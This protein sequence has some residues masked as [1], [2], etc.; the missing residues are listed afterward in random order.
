LEIQELRELEDLIIDAIYMGI[1]Q[2]SLDQKS[3]Q[4]EV[5]FSM[6]RDLKPE[7]LDRMINVLNAW[8][9]QSENIQ[10]T[11]KEKIQHANTMFELEKKHKEE[12]EKRVENIKQ[13]LKAALDAE[14]LQAAEL[15]GA[16]PFEASRKGRGKGLKG[17]SREPHHPAPHHRD[18]R[19]R[20][21]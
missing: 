10:K 8:S 17:M 2:G 18:V 12:F 5:E 16:D 11:I 7:D 14:M 6:G 15:E 19:E 1:I 13:N 3:K 9:T 21:G 20:R 4:L